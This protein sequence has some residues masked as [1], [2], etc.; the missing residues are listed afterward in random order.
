ML[1]IYTHR[2]E[3]PAGTPANSVGIYLLHGAGEHAGRYQQLANR[4]TALGFIVGAHDH[5]GHGRSAGSRGLIDPPGALSIQAAIQ[6]QAFTA[7]TGCSPVLFGHSLGGVLAAELVLQHGLDVPGLILSAPAFVPRMSKADQIKLSVLRSFAPKLCIEFPY[8]ASVLTSDTEQRLI[9]NNDE[10]NHG[11]KSASL[12]AWLV[13]SGRRS[14]NL[15]STLNTDTLLLIAGA[16]P[17][18][19]SDCTREFASQST[20]DRLTVH[21]YDGYLHEPLN[22]SAQKR[23]QVLHDIETWVLRFR[24]SDR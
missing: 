16:D 18:V 8:D 4:L 9:A 17:I 22:E 10:L 14:L 2:W 24:D 1:S 13:A 19:D 6:I 5:S 7:E 21:D 15:A 23:E 20:S 12:V 3:P 11:F